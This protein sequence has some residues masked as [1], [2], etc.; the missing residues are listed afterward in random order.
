M[1]WYK[2]AQ[3]SNTMLGYKVMKVEDGQF[4]SGADSRVKLPPQVGVIHTM[5]GVGIFLGRTP[6]YVKDYY[7]SGGFEPED[8]KEF[9]LTY[10]F[11][12]AQII[13]GNLEDREW[14]ISV[15]SAKLIN[16]EQLN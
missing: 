8:P 7:F 15:P 11:N 1:N 14:E 6:E 16:M 13:S 9:L 12:P 5:P 4:V 10:E 2:T 3:Q